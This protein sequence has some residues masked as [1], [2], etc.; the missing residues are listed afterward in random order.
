MGSIGRKLTAEWSDM[1]QLPRDFPKHEPL[2]IM[3]FF[4]ILE[5]PHTKYLRIPF[6][7]V[8]ESIFSTEDLGI[9]DA[10]MLTSLETFSLQNY[11]YGG[12]NGTIFATGANFPTLLQLGDLLQ[13]QGKAMD[14]FLLTKLPFQLTQEMK[15]SLHQTKKLIRISD[16]LPSQIRKDAMESHL[17]TQGIKHIEIHYL[18]PQYDLLTTIF[19]EYSA[20]QAKFD[21]KG[22]SER[23]ISS[24]DFS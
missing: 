12:N 9:I 14:I 7:H 16:F 6:Q 13:A 2:D 22:L 1:E 18:H 4:K 15:T 24:P 23:I 8:P 5:Q 3:N 19:D 21:A 10:Q 20:Q 11:G 17:H